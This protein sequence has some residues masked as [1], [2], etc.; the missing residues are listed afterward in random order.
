MPRVSEQL[1][2]GLELDPLTLASSEHVHRWYDYVQGFDPE[3]AARKL[4]DHGGGADCLVLDPFCGSGTTLVAALFL[5]CRA[6]GVDANPLMRLVSAAKST[7]DVPLA[8]FEERADEVLDRLARGAGADGE[9]DAIA[10]G[11]PM[12]SV[13]KW[14]RAPVLRE[15]V[16]TRRILADLP[17][18]DGR[19]M[20]LL[21]VAYAKAMF[22]SSQVSMCPGITFVKRPRAGLS[23]TL[24]RKCR[25]IA[26]DL[27]LLRELGLHTRE[28]ADVL[29]ADARDLG[30]RLAA[31][32]ADLVFTSPPYPTDIEY[33]RQSRA[34]LFFLDFIRTMEDVRRIKKTMVRGSPKN[35]Y[36]ADHNERWVAGYGEVAAVSAAIHEKIKG[37]N[38]GWDYA[39]MV[40][41]YFGDMLLCLREMLR[42]LRPGGW[43]L[44]V[45]GDQTCKGVMIPVTDILLKIGRDLGFADHY[46]EQVR[47]RR[48]TTHSMS[49]P[50]NVLALRK[51][52]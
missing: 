23:A 10:C 2:L 31:N 3:L 18:T 14:F 39:R 37:K 8:Q 50:E 9:E 28:P 24:K 6:A 51:P 34:E 49:L 52:P 41:E 38:W 44:L 48:S 43:A 47:E 15:V 42:V 1:S 21:R 7:W 27:R 4:H 22:E 17:P 13:S 30:G 32:G 11:I 20:R 29:E 19:V 45:I 35:I 12:K 16:A 33:T 46:V 26:A 36:K 5:G 25:T 40:R